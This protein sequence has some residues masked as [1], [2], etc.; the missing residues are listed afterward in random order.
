MQTWKQGWQIIPPTAA[1]ESPDPQGVAD[2]VHWQVWSAPHD[3]PDGHPAE[4]GLRQTP[5]GDW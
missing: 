2:G 3:S 5:V 1:H 4:Q